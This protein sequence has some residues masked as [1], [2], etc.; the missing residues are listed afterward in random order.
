M[1]KRENQ[2]KIN[3]LKNYEISDMH[4][5]AKVSSSNKVVVPENFRKHYDITAGD[6]ISWTN[7]DI[8]NRNFQNQHRN[9][10]CRE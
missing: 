5:I 4:A 2:I 3:N 10:E 1:I 8:A 6:E 7:T 9:F